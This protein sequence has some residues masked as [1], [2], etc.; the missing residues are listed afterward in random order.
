M[1]DAIIQ[2]RTG[3]TRLPGKVFKLLSGKPLLWHVVN[4]L[5][6]SKFINRIIVAT[7]NNPLDDSIAL[8]CS[9]NDV[10]FYRGDEQNVLDRYYKTAKHYKSDIVVRVTADDPFKDPNVIDNVINKLQTETLDFAYNNFPPSFP[11]GLDTEVFTFSAIEKAFFSANDDF[12][13]EHVTQYF[14]RNQAFFKTGNFSNSVN[15]S[16]LRWT[17]DTQL[18]FEMA[19][20]VYNNLYKDQAL[21]VMEDI[22]S[23]INQYPKI[24]A[25]NLEVQRSAMYTK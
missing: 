3:S 6:Y 16:H 25:H 2:A 23:L 1:I 9:Q 20:M 5:S 13:K 24:A 7:T 21:F 17:I 12:E 10:L 14:Y 19:E 22:L 18:D 8:W 15:L 4:R 11:E